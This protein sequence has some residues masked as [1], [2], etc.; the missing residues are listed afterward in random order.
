MNRL[1]IFI[2]GGIAGY[3]ASGWIEGFMETREK[4]ASDAPAAQEVQ[5]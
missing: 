4:P 1:L 2:V 3:I 5:P